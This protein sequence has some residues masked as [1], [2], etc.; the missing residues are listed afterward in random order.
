MSRSTGLDADCGVEGLAALLVRYPPYARLITDGLQDGV[1]AVVGQ[2]NAAK[3]IVELNGRK[4]RWTK[5]EEE[6]ASK[7]PP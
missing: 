2:R 6:L 3:R 1:A 5:E 7:H 4:K